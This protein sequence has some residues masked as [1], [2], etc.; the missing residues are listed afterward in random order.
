MTA[1]GFILSPL[2]AVRKFG[3]NYP[4]LPHGNVL[5]VEWQ[6]HSAQQM[7]KAKTGIPTVGARNLSPQ[8]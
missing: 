6:Q 1:S 7:I 4:K 5:V 2:H 8:L 3:W